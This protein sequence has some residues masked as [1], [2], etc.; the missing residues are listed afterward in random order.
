MDLKKEKGKP[1]KNETKTYVLQVEDSINIPNTSLQDLP[2][3]GR[4]KKRIRGFSLKFGENP[5]KVDCIEFHLHT[6]QTF[7]DI[8]E[9]LALAIDV[10]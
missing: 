2:H 3:A 1:K 5:Y 4:G 8:L 6:S 10:F 9:K 7:T